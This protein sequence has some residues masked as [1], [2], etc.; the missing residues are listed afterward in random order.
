MRLIGSCRRLPLLAIAA[1][2]FFDLKAS[3]L[4]FNASPNSNFGKVTKQRNRL[5]RRFYRPLIGD[6]RS[7]Q[8]GPEPAGSWVDGGKRLPAVA[9]SRKSDVR[10]RQNIC[11]IPPL[12]QVGRR[13]SKALCIVLLAQPR[14]QRVEPYLQRRQLALRVVQRERHIRGRVVHLADPTWR[15][16]ETSALGVALDGAL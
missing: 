8:R 11:R 6:H 3:N 12:S 5:A 7:D 14:I 16:V 13:H 9:N 10:F 2:H 1:A 4:W 15:R